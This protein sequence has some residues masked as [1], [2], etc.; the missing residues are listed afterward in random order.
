VDPIALATVTAAVSV[1]ATECAKGVATSV[2]KDIWI[3][4]KDLM[5]WK[6][7]PTLGDLAPTVAQQLNSNDALAAKIVDLLK[8][9]SS[10][11][12]T[13]AGPLVERINAKNVVVAR[14]L[15]VSGDLN[16]GER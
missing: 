10:T 7:E 5:G 14:E 13:A 11:D 8:S 9:G 16:M 3:Q 2:G 4:V 12:Q 6:K 1:L 15:N